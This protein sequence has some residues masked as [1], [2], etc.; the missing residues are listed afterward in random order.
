MVFF[1]DPYY[2]KPRVQYNVR[3]AMSSNPN[4][5]LDPS[6]AEQRPEITEAINVA[7]A[8][9]WDVDESM[10]LRDILELAVTR[11]EHIRDQARR[12]RR[13]PAQPGMEDADE[14]AERLEAEKVQ[15]N[16][17][18]AM[19]FLNDDNAQIGDDYVPLQP[20][21]LPGPHRFDDDGNFSEL[22]DTTDEDEES[23]Y[24]SSSVNYRVANR[25]GFIDDAAAEAEPEDEEY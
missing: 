13:D 25:S 22:S 20:G 19:N 24:A 8:A 17:R 10:S 6:D 11:R 21:R 12:Q 7:A 9:H 18:R 4:V 3:R 23:L 2:K 16:V 15:R 14:T 5:S 1:Y